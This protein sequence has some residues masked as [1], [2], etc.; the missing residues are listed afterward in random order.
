MPID[1]TEKMG[2]WGKKVPTHLPNVHITQTN[3]K[4]RDAQ[5][6]HVTTNIPGTQAKV[7]DKF[8]ANGNYLGSSFGK[9]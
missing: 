2:D 5:G 6:G 3:K 4:A 7:H 8:D 9:R 1:G